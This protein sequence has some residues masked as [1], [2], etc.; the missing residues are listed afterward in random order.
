MTEENMRKKQNFKIKKVQHQISFQKGKNE[1]PESQSI[2]AINKT[3]FNFKWT[4]FKTTK[5]E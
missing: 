5:T 1:T 4:R 3:Q 2:K